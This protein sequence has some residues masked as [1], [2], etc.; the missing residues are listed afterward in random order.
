MWNRR[1]TE[2]CT[3]NLL[4]T[5]NTSFIITFTVVLNNAFILSSTSGRVAKSIRNL[6]CVSAAA[7]PG[8][9]PATSS[10][11]LVRDAALWRNSTGQSPGARETWAAAKR[12]WMHRIQPK[13]TQERGGKRH[14]D[15]M[16][17]QKKMEFL[18]K[19]HA[20]QLVYGSQRL[21]LM[22]LK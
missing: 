9:L 6:S 12:R 2:P 14:L 5:N 7:F 11:S 13:S 19:C 17:Q 15:P 8:R 20:V 10:I 21:F 22:K 4:N 16:G 1:A 3:E 18:Q